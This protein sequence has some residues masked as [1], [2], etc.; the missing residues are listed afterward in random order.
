MPAHASNKTPNSEKGACGAPNPARP[1][2]TV[3]TARMS[4][5]NVKI[6]LTET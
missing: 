3:G 5:A 2:S 1:G 4:Q 6:G